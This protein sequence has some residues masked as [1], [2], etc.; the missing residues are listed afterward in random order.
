MSHTAVYPVYL[1]LSMARP[2]SKWSVSSYFIPLRRFSYQDLCQSASDA[3]HPDPYPGLQV[4]DG[5]PETN[6]LSLH[7]VLPTVHAHFHANKLSF[8]V[9]PSPSV[10]PSFVSRST[11]PHLI[12][13]SS[14]E[15]PGDLLSTARDGLRLLQPLIASL[16][17]KKVKEQTR[18]G[19]RKSSRG[20]T[21]QHPLYRPYHPVQVH[22]LR[23]N[24]TSKVP[25]VLRARS[26]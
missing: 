6:T 7:P 14:Q 26:R 2:S 1:Q 23:A 19:V 13:A 25:N 8:S 24:L 17:T 9:T 3:A 10:S 16:S 4:D 21:S 15:R 20:G 22:Y 12:S 11:E 18:G 5:L